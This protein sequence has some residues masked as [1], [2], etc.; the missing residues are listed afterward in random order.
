MPFQRS[1]NGI[2]PYCVLEYVPTALH[3]AAPEHDT[4][5]TDSLSAYAS[6]GTAN[7]NAA[8]TVPFHCS[9]SATSEYPYGLVVYQPVATQLVVPLHETEV[10]ANAAYETG[11][12]TVC[13]DQTDPFHASAIPTVW[14]WPPT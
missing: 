14:S 8:Q 13:R 3:V 12:G 5:E 1:I 2:S 9:A 7:D 11:S 4:E 10:S 6:E